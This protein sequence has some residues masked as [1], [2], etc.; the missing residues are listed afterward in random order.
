MDPLVLGVVVLAVL[1][2]SG[3]LC[4][5]GG[6]LRRSSFTAPQA[7]V[8]EQQRRLYEALTQVYM[9]RLDIQKRYGGF[10]G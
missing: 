3:L 1:V 5:I 7:E 4:A 2:V 9:D 8:D 6:K 10:P